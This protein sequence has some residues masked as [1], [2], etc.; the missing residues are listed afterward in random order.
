MSSQGPGVPWGERWVREECRSQDNDDN[1]EAK[2]D[3]KGGL[4]H[5]ASGHATLE[6]LLA[7]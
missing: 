1:K 5:V 7:G 2:K 4:G 3:G 6:T